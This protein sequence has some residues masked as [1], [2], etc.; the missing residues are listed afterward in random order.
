ME[1]ILSQTQSSSTA[2]ANTFNKAWNTQLGRINDLF[3][4]I[5]DE[6]LTKEIAPGRNTGI[7]VLGH[8]AAVHDSM[9]PLLGFG[10]KLYPQLEEPFIKS[11]DNSGHTFPP[12][13]DLKNYWNEINALLGKH[14]TELSPEGWLERHNSISAEDFAKEPHRN[15]LSVLISRTAHMGYHQGQL[16]WL[17]KKKKGL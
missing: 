11:P 15:K 5:P 10:Q 4:A 8:L 9:L 7:Y 6:D 17:K 14:F 1:T 2:F 16:A 13:S 12:V 3:A